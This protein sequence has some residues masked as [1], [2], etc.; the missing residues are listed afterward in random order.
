M[1]YRSNTNSYWKLFFKCDLLNHWLMGHGLVGHRFWP[2]TRV[3]H[4][5]LLTHLTLDPWP[6]THWSFCMYEYDVV[7]KKLTFAISSPDEFLLIHSLQKRKFIPSQLLETKL[8]VGWSDVTVIFGHT[9]IF[10]L[11]GNTAYCVELIK[12]CC[13]I[14]LFILFKKMYVLSQSY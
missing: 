3:T 13:V 12:I 4:P 6:M 1:F 11:C 7:V 8:Y 2:M 5:D 10:M 9:T 14:R